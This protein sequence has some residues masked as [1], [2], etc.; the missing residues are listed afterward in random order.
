MTNKNNLIRYI[1]YFIRLAHVTKLDGV[2]LERSMSS[3]GDRY[4]LIMI[5]KIA[6]KGAL[7]IVSNLLACQLIMT[8]MTR[9]YKL[10]SF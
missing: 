9:L 8:L 10:L 1:V 2:L 4:R 6:Q 7:K 3:S 5:L